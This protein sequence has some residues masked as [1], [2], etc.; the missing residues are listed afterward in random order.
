VD[1]GLLATYPSAATPMSAMKPSTQRNAFG[2]LD[3]RAVLTIFFGG[4][5]LSLGGSLFGGIFRGRIH[6]LTAEYAVTRK[7]REGYRD[8]S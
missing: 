6:A 8:A 2:R 5:F 7:L 3:A 4:A 1:F